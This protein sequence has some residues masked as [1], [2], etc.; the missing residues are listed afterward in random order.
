MSFFD[1]LRR[2]ILSIASVDAF[3]AELEAAGRPSDPPVL[4]TEF[5]MIGEAGGLIGDMT[6]A[7]TD[8]VRRHVQHEFS[9]WSDEL[10]LAT[11]RA[12]AEFMPYAATA[13]DADL[14][15]VLRAPADSARRQ[16]WAGYEVV[17]MYLILHMLR[18]RDVDKEAVAKG[19][20]TGPLYE[21]HLPKLIGVLYERV[22]GGSLPTFDGENDAQA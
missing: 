9:E 4:K 20:A 21:D 14:P 2:H 17:L 5:C 11:S 7:I 13:E 16:M 6:E 10:K 22:I 18:M 12:A 15:E 3:N 19:H 8:H 1:K